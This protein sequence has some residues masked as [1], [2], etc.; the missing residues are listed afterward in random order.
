MKDFL[1]AIE[2]EELRT[3]IRTIL[4]RLLTLAEGQVSPIGRSS[5]SS[6]APLG[7]PGFAGLTGR[8]CP[9]EDR[10][11]F[12][13]FRW[14]FEKAIE[15]GLSRKRLYFL[16]WEAEKAY[17]IRT[18]PPQED[19][20]PRRALILT[21]A[22]EGALR[23]HVLEKY[24]GE[25]SYRVHLDLNLPQ[26]WVEKVRED[27]S[28]EPETGLRRPRWRDLSDGLKRELIARLQAEGRTQAE[29]AKYLGISRRTVSNYRVDRAA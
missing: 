12:D 19:D 10:S 21:R 11:L 5:K 13:H 22:N 24:E 26:G 9:P 2:D 14:R 25:H 4:A 16:L 20:D 17:E 27:D 6:E 18:V 23:R 3:E 15:S 8:D 1:S 7:P 28:R 29:V